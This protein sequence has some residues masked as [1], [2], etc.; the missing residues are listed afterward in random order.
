MNRMELEE[1]DE[2]LPQPDWGKGA[3]STSLTNA[4]TMLNLAGGLVENTTLRQVVHSRRRV[5]TITAT[6]FASVEFTVRVRRIG[7]PVVVARDSADFE[8]YSSGEHQRQVKMAPVRLAVSVVV[9]S[10]QPVQ[11]EEEEALHYDEA[12]PDISPLAIAPR[13]S[14]EGVPRE[15]AKQIDYALDTC[16]TLRIPVPDFR[17]LA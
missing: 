13:E 1:F 10:P 3:Q 8:V 4:L 11:E 12:I 5:A 2:A 16:I 14:P 17:T 6:R 9:V 7:R 15:W